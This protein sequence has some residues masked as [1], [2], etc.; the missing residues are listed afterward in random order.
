MKKCYPMSRGTNQQGKS[1]WCSACNQW[2]III[3]V[4]LFLSLSTY[5]IFKLTQDPYRTIMGPLCDLPKAPEPPR[6]W[7][8][9]SWGAGTVDSMD[10]DTVYMGSWLTTDTLEA[11]LYM[12]SSTGGRR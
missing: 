6:K 8:S 7:T 12:D 10:V 5:G 4:I 1:G 2:Q 11:W 9:Y 3:I